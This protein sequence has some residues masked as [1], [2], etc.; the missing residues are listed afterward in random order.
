METVML[1]WSQQE[2]FHELF[3]KYYQFPWFD[4]E[5]SCLTAI[6][7]PSNSVP[8]IEIW[9]AF[10]WAFHHAISFICK[11]WKQG[12][13]SCKWYRQKLTLKTDPNPPSPILFAA[14]KVLVGA[15]LICLKV[16]K[17]VFKSNPLKT[18]GTI[19]NSY[20][21]YNIQWKLIQ[22]NATCE[23]DWNKQRRK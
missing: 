8:C 1:V 3:K 6:M 14:S 13:A 7:V 2:L 23:D 4:L 19:T 16:K 22:D 15:T 11:N 18:V 21:Y 12:K 20:M 10:R 9:H 5:E 17:P